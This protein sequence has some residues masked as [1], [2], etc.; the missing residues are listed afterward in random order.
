MY[1]DLVEIIPG[2]WYEAWQNYILLLFKVKA[3]KQANENN[4][5]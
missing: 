3:L 2:I 4:K 1:F 5:D